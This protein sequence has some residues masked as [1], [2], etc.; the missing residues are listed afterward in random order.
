[1]MI[2]TNQFV[3]LTESD[4]KVYIQTLK[5]GLALKEFEIILR[6]YPRIKLS[7]FALLKKSL[8]NEMDQPVQIGEWLPVCE[9]DISKDGMSAYIIVHETNNTI[10]NN[11]ETIKKLIKDVLKENHVIH[12]IKELDVVSL[13]TGK[14]YEI[15]VGTQ[16][17]KGNDAKVEY[18]EIPERKPIIRDDGRADFFDMNFIFEIKEGAWL[19]EKTPASEGIE[20]INIFGNPVA[21]PPGKDVS[22]K[23]DPHSAYE[24]EEDGKVVIRAK[25][26]GVVEHRQGLISVNR[27]L[28]I[29]GDVGIE[30]GNIQFDGS[31]SIRGTVQNGYSVTANGDI[32]IEGIDGVTGAKL[33]QSIEGDIYIRGGIFGNNETQVI[34]GG[35]IFVK[36]V[37]DANLS[38]G[39][40]III[41][42]YSLGSNLEA[43]KIL[44]DERKGKIIG[45]KAVALN[46]IVTA[47]AGNHL[48]RRT[49][50]IINNSDKKKA[51]E[52]IQK[53][54][55]N[56][57][58]IHEEIIQLSTHLNPLI[59]YKEQLTGQQLAVVDEKI[60]YLNDLK[61]SAEKLDQEI[62]HLMQGYQQVGKEK[63]VVRK[64]AFPGTFIDIGFKSSHLTK[65]QKGTFLIEF[66]ELNV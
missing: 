51:L 25:T 8:L 53:K 10:Q 21:A 32:S 31:I 66:G 58:I 15:A 23:F 16:P 64:E 28:P 52:V 41:G 24:V 33:I 26:T 3:K 59:Q 37:N 46:T 12:G 49:E 7:H 34:A 44:V 19:G 30:T 55:A 47:I 60:L 61:K 5:K 4:E 43:A 13:I 56:L 20:G 57:K 45:G 29:I 48:E 1:M 27:H 36:H 22:I 17:V 11:I 50:L 63:I 6:Q 39:N 62:K 2:F 14:P 54:A 40:E 18:L 35:N 9:I 38:A 65:K 42:S